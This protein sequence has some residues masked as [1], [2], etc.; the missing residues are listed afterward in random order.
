[1]H[2]IVN[3]DVC[4]QLVFNFQVFI[5]MFFLLNRKYDARTIKIIKEDQWVP[6]NQKAFL[7]W[8]T[9]TV[10]HTESHPEKK[11]PLKWLMCYSSSGSDRGMHGGEE[12]CSTLL[13][14]ATSIRI[15]KMLLCCSFYCWSDASQQP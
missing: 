15:S 11:H 12:L 5:S 10:N 13:I 7:I 9:S 3:R 14:L 2:C 6:K 1:M 8:K 4:L